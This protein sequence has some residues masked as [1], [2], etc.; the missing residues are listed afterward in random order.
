MSYNHA[1]A[2]GLARWR[3]LFAILAM[4]GLAS[5][6]D[7]PTTS[8]TATLSAAVSTKFAAGA[9]VQVVNGTLNVRATPSVNGTLLGTQVV[10]N[11]GTIVGGPVY[12]STGDQLWRWNVNFDQGADGWAAEYYLTQVGSVPPPSPAPV[13]TVTVSPST[14]SGSVGQTAQLTATLKD[15]SGTVL[16]GRT[17]TWSSSNTAI[18]GVS[19]SGL[20]TASGAGTAAITATSES[21]TGSATVTVTAGSPPPPV[22]TK[23]AIGDRVQVVNGTLNVRATPSING[24][25]LGTQVVGNLGTVVGGPILDANGDKMVRWNVNFDQGADGWAAEYYLTKNSSGPPP[26]PAPVASVTVSP[27][28]PI[29]AVGSTAQLGATTKDSAGTVLTGRSI[30]WSTRH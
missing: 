14:V 7:A 23:F 2:S 12:D 1:P 4:I 29:V 21:K 15:S 24:A 17:I 20:V 27:S 10:G 11:L 3:P 19:A 5:C 8:R 26:S 30:T 9:R 16:T 18:A 13:A 28:A 6:G 25:L 22:S